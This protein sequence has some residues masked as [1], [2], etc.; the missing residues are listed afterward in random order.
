M[1]HGSKKAMLEELLINTIYKSSSYWRC[2]LSH[3]L[4]EWAS[5]T[6]LLI[7][8]VKFIRYLYLIRN[9]GK[10]LRYN[11]TIQKVVIQSKRR[12][13][14]ENWHFSLVVS[15]MWVTHN[16]RAFYLQTVDL[17]VWKYEQRKKKLLFNSKKLLR[18]CYLRF[19]VF[20]AEYFA[21]CPNLWKFYCNQPY[22]RL[23]KK[24]RSFLRKKGP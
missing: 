6:V 24:T 16:Y 20:L 14:L 22:C 8:L 13:F 4:Y 23:K 19:S 7:F 1:Q 9:E 11:N 10:T 12:I 2:I 17:L 18:N 21:F 3:I 15:K 5:C